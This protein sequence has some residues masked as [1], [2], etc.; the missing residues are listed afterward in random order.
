MASYGG[1]PWA[2]EPPESLYNTAPLDQRFE[3]PFEGDMTLSLK[4]MVAGTTEGVLI[5]LPPLHPKV[6]LKEGTKVTELLPRC[7]TLLVHADV[8]QVFL[9]FRIEISQEKKS[10]TSQI[11]HLI[12][13]DAE[14]EGTESME[15][16]I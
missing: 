1:C 10:T 15:A 14:E 9:L 5:N 4:G 8:Q 7:D 13:L 16:T 6:F 11:V 12:D 3:Q 2:K